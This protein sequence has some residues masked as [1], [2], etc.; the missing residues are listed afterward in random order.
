MSCNLSEVMLFIGSSPEIRILSKDYNKIKKVFDKM[1]IV[2][3]MEVH[4]NDERN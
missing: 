3:E 4:Y 1:K 2:Y